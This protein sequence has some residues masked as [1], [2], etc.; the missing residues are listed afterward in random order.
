VAKH[1]GAAWFSSLGRRWAVGARTLDLTAEYKYASGTRDPLDPSRVGT[2]D[3]L[4]PS[5]HDKFGHMDLFGWRNI[6]AAR[7]LATLGI[8]KAFA[9]NLM[10][11][12][13]WLASTRDALY[14][15]SGRAIAR[16]VSG[17]AGR[18]V[19]QEVDLF[20]TY[21]FQR[22]TFGGGY[23]RLFKGDFIRGTTPG[24]EPT[25]VYVFHTYS[26]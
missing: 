16:S 21:K 6:H 22:F 8:I 3:A 12:S 11:D 2:F 7:S 4:F 17:T 9:V 26:L 20:A 18:H 19:G 24:V 13:W 15:T 5:T 25:Y 14:N 10:Y 23:G 1:R